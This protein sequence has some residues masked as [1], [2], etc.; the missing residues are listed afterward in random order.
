LITA[1]FLSSGIGFITRKRFVDISVLR[2]LAA[3]SFEKVAFIAC[4]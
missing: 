3:L 1:V 2:S 4:C